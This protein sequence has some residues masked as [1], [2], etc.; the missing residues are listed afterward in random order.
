MNY[1][2]MMGEFLVFIR[3]TQLAADLRIRLGLKRTAFLVIALI[4]AALA[5]VFINIA[6]YV[7]LQAIIGAIWTPAL[8]AIINFFLMLIVLAIASSYR[9]SDELDDARQLQSSSLRQLQDELTSPRPLYGFLDPEL[10]SELVPIIVALVR[11]MRTRE[12]NSKSD[13]KPTE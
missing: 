2:K 9:T 4:F 3:S 1:R 8:L 13:Q 12:K 11:A 6:A 5:L 10:V 7:A